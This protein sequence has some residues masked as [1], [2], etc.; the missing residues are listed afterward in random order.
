[1]ILIMIVGYGIKISI[2]EKKTK[3]KK[4][5]DKPASGLSQVGIYL[6]ER[7]S[8]SDSVADGAALLYPVSV[9]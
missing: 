3:E 4:T 2:V 8:G 1:M 7:T 5:I 9:T 6:Y